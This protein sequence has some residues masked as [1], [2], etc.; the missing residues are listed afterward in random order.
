MLQIHVFYIQLSDH[1]C[2]QVK[3]NL[4]VENCHLR[5]WAL[6]QESLYEWIFTLTK[7]KSSLFIHPCLRTE[8]QS[9]VAFLK[10][11]YGFSI[12]IWD[13]YIKMPLIFFK[14]FPLPQLWE[15]FTMLSF[16]DSPLT[17][18]K[19][20]LHFCNLSGHK[21]T[22]NTDVPCR[23]GGQVLLAL[24]SILFAACCLGRI[25]YCCFA[26]SNLIWS[27]PECLLVTLS[28]HSQSKRWSGR[29]NLF[30]REES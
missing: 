23:L 18:H 10:I 27:R 21:F 19:L 11:F 3:V 26:I 7:N 4:Y 2:T 14:Y 30:F 29:L 15:S 17:Y 6:S 16:A 9:A 12:P 13:H 5:C 24:Y 28:S 22:L 8:C 1:S 20:I 25:L